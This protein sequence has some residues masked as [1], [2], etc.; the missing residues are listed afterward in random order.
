ML[1]EAL[2]EPFNAIR[3]VFTEEQ[4]ALYKGRPNMFLVESHEKAWHV[5]ISPCILLGFVSG[6]P[7]LSLAHP[8]L[9]Y[10]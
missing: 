7:H 10:G 9:G 5:P 2:L 6:L 1:L 4:N 8:G 3:L